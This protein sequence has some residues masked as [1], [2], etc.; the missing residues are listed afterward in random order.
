VISSGIPSLAQELRT[1]LRTNYGQIEP[2]QLAANEKCMRTPWH[3]T[4]PIETLFSQLTTTFEFAQAGNAGISELH[5]I[6]IGYEI[7]QATGMFKDD[8][9][10]WHDKPIAQYT[11]ANFKIFFKKANRYRLSTTTDGGYHTANAAVSTTSTEK[12]SV[13]ATLKAEIAA[14]KKANKTKNVPSTISTSDSTT[15]GLTSYCHTHGT[16]TN[17]THSSKTCKQKGK[18]HKDNATEENKMGGSSRVWSNSDRKPRE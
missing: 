12:D 10:T 7:I 13:I 4:E 9:K 16:S 5:V 11:L 1:H 15:S 14:L 8:L 6:R 2:A 17:L 18:D 3:T